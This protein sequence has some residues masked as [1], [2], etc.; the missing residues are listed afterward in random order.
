MRN[1]ME[2]QQRVTVT[3]VKR[4]KGVLDSGQA[5]DSTKAFVV[6]PMDAS[7]GDAAGSSAEPFT[8]GTSDVF[9]AW[10]KL[11][12]PVEAD[13]TMEIVTSGSSTRIQIR[14]I[15]PAALKAAKG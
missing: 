2:F 7:K 8:I 9:A 5:Y 11:P 14:A 13:A 12:F 4:S 6:L 3:G 15:V 10:A 1:I